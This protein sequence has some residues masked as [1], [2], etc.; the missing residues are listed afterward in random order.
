MLCNS[1][2]L[3]SKLTKRVLILTS[4]S[5]SKNSTLL[6]KSFQSRASF[7]A[8][9]VRPEVISIASFNSS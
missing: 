8:S 9:I 4:T 3:F 6:I 1:F 2:K 5:F 7:T